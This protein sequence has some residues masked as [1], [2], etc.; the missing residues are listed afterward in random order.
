MVALGGG[1]SWRSPSRKCH[2]GRLLCETLGAE[3]TVSNP[4]ATLRFTSGMSL[5]TTWS[6]LYDAI[7]TPM[8]SSELYFV[9]IGT[10][11]TGIGLGARA[12]AGGRG[13]PL[14]KERPA[15]AAM[16]L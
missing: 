9:R 16:P 3:G 4:A 2:D 1:A 10:G 15:A 8:S 6:S 11:L 5:A 13:L 12:G 7:R 14:S